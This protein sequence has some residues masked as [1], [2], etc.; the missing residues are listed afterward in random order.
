[1]YADLDDRYCAAAVELEIVPVVA[2]TVVPWSHSVAPAA[3]AA[4]IVET[5]SHLGAHR[6]RHSKKD[7]TPMDC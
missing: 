6:Y 1:M 3:A 7:S 4:E 5:T 2:A